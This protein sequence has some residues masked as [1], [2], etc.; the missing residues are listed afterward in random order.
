MFRT[1]STEGSQFWNETYFVPHFQPIVNA[2]NR[3]ISAYEVLGRRFN[4]EEN[5]YQSLGG[6]FHN[7]EEDPVPVYNIDRI[8]REKA[9]QRLKESSLRTKLFFN[10]MPNFLSRV[11]HTDLF[12]ENFHIIQLIEKYEIDRN[13]VVNRNHRG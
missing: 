13:Q 11:H 2:I 3:S 4:P 6:L 12:A 8:L 10:M 1:E 7:R 5:T 9:I